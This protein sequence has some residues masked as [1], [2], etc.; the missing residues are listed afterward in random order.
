MTCPECGADLVAEVFSIDGT[1]RLRCTA[2]WLTLA[3][4]AGMAG[5]VLLF[6]PVAVGSDTAFLALPAPGRRG[7]REHTL[8]VR[9]R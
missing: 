2:R 4:V 3:V 1:R 5:V 9:S 8:D 7:G 6:G